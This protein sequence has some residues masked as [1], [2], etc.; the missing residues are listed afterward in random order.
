MYV[1]TA[2][3]LE[4][5]KLI[6]EHDTDQQKIDIKSIGYTALALFG[7]TEPNSDSTLEYL[8]KKNA[9]PDFINFVTMCIE[10]QA[11]VD[12]LLKVLFCRMV[13]LS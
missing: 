13:Q 8:A 1:F 10:G 9:S 4:H 5:G 7:Y 6:D 11:P 3:R 2:G 12:Q